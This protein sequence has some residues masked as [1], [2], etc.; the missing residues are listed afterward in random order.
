M[1]D[2]L[3][4]TPYD[5]VVTTTTYGGIPEACRRLAA[6]AV[7]DLWR[8]PP[9]DERVDRRFLRVLAW[10][11]MIDERFVDE[12]L[13]VQLGVDEMVI[14]GHVVDR[15]APAGTPVVLVPGSGMP[16]K[17]WPAARWELLAS[18]LRTAGHPVLVAG[19]PDQP[20]IAGTVRLPPGDL[21][22]L[23]SQ[24]AAVG[25]RGGLVVGPDTGPVRLAVAT[26]TPAVVLFGPTAASR[27]GAD[28]ALAVSLQG[29]PGCEIRRPTSIAEQECWWSAHCP[30][31]GA[32]P[33]CMARPFR[34]A[35]ALRSHCH[36]R[37]RVTRSPV[38]PQDVCCHRAIRTSDSEG[39]DVTA[40]Q[41]AVEADRAL[42][43]KHRAMWALGDYPAVVDDLVGV[44]GPILVEAA[45]VRA[46]DRVLDVG[47]G[48]GN[49]AI[50]AA[51][52]GAQV[53][54][55][56]LTPEL[57]ERGR[58]AAEQR[59]ATLEWRE[60]D[61]ENLP[62]GDAEFD[63]VLSCVGVMFAPHHQASADELVRV[64][65]PGGTI[66]LLSWTPRGLHRADVRNDEAIRAAASARCSTAAAVGQ[67]GARPRAARRPGDRCR[68]SP[69]DPEGRALRRARGVPRL[70]Q[71]Q[72]RADHRRLSATSP[73]TPTGS[74]HW[75]ATSPTSLAGSTPATAGPSWSGSTCSSLPS[76][77]RCGD[78]T[79][80]RGTGSPRT[81]HR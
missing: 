27:Y 28:P 6:E 53:I 49:A 68:G 23:A 38:D 78:V 36:P 71:G 2:E 31:T 54:A 65:R 81:P 11:G 35:G 32:A 25:V 29:L 66:G 80:R 4:R 69:A 21:R 24:L 43:A 14:G 79:G 13:H 67:R 5:L 47:S 1:E 48:S 30:L 26:G 39:A 41:D 63:V 62:F 77:A 74:R 45:G 56:D 17:Q 18:A 50:P 44:L 20:R 55:S 57:F 61:A 34:G 10:D 3:T 60:A 51:L 72:L 8:D 64:C 22:A 12:P 7:T 37:A 19:R 15:L 73:T 40:T 16:V 75:T 46:G 59:G 76:A 9:P 70:L 33:A 52:A 58:Q 42:K